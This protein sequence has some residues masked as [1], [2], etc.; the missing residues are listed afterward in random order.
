[1]SHRTMATVVVLL[2]VVLVALAVAIPRI[3][4]QVDPGGG[5]DDYAALEPAPDS[6]V[7][8]AQEGWTFRLGSNVGGVDL[9]IAGVALGVAGIG[10]P[11]IDSGTAVELA[12]GRGCLE[13][14]VSLV[15]VSNIAGAAAT[16]SIGVDR[17]VSASDLTVYQRLHAADQD[18]PATSTQA[19]IGNPDVSQDTQL[20]SLQEGQR[21][22]VDVSLDAHFPPG[23]TR[24]VTFVAG[25]P[26]SATPARGGQ[27]V[28]VFEDL[29]WELLACHE[30]E[31]VL[32]SLHGSDGEEL[33]RYLVDV[34]PA[35]PPTPVPTAAPAPPV[36][37]EDYIAARLSV[38]DAVSRDLYFVGGEPVATVLATGGTAPLTYSLAPAANSLDFVFFALDGSTGAVTVSDGGADDHAGLELDH[39][40]TFRV[41]ATDANGL[42]ADAYVAVQVVRP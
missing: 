36:F 10:S 22:R 27:V 39:I 23:L 42:A 5:Q 29:T 7:W 11:G 41:G 6:V 28:P 3:V 20:A 15:S 18:L 35:S 40:Y 17:G 32:V 2:V 14:V 16:L 34:L 38:V 24:S 31:D 30:A 25:E 26:G 33:R 13:A 4:I 37:P 21:Y 12:Q 8:R 9:R 19:T 1:M